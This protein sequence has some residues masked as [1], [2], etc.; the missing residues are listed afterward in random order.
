MHS[1]AF[2]SIASLP[3]R[4]RR[5]RRSPS[6]MTPSRLPLW[7]TVVKLSKILFLEP[8]PL[9]E[10]YSDRVSKCK[11]RGCTCRG[12]KA[13]IASLARNGAIECHVRSLSKCGLQVAGEGNQ[14]ISDPFDL[15]QKL[16]EFF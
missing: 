3:R 15:R 10:R 2:R 7:A 4:S 13:Q 9:R 1:L 16:K 12:S 6:L 11:H 8:A 5:R 14:R